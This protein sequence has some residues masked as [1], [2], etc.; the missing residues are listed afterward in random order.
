MD[1]QMAMDTTKVEG[2]VQATTGI[3]H[4]RYGGRRRLG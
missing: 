2:A 1:A 4:E 3:D